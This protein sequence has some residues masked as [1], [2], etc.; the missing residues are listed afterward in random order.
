MDKRIKSKDSI[1]LKS[2]KTNKLNL[3]SN[4]CKILLVSAQTKCKMKLKKILMKK[5]RLPINQVESKKKTVQPV[6]SLWMEKLKE[7]NQDQKTKD[8]EV[9]HLE[10]IRLFWNWSQLPIKK[11]PSNF[12]NNWLYKMSYKALAS[13]PMSKE[14][15]TMLWMSWLRWEF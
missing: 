1:F 14:E 12:W 9:F 11:L 4:P 2:I 6:I 13:K 7:K 10:L 3:T 15:S 8:F 5:L